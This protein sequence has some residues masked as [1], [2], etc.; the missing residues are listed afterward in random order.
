MNL[1][2]FGTPEGWLAVAGLAIGTFA[3]RYSFIGLLAGRKLP[4]RFERALQLAVPA[5]FAALVLPLILFHNG[6]LNLGVRWPHA[7]AA[8]LTGIY[9]WWRGGMVTTLL[10]GMGSLHALLWLTAR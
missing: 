1:G 9:A 5:I 4:P 8:V 3:I 2:S 10:I 7:V 6:N